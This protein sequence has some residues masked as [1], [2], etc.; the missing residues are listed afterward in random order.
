M[1]VEQGFSSLHLL[2]A[3]LRE[4][5]GHVDDSAVFLLVPFARELSLPRAEASGNA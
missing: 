5:R 2:D 1:S 4:K 3:T